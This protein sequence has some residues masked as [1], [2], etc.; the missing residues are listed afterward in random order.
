[1]AIQIQGANGI[2]AEVD[3]TTF[4]A[5]R[6]T[7]RPAEYGAFGHYRICMVSGTMAAALAANSDIFLFRWGDTTRLAVVYEVVISAGANVAASA[8]AITSLELFFARTFTASGTGGTPA[9]LSGNNQKMRTSMGTTLATDI[10]C[11][12]TTALG[13]GTKTLDAQ[14]LSGVAVGIWTGALTTGL[15]GQFVPRTPL[16]DVDG[17]FKHP[18]VFAQDEGFAIRNGIIF[19]A[20]LTWNFAVSVAWLEYTSF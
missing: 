2:V 6:V 15:S 17:G 9:T 16:I 18:I 10:R 3:G 19:P 20:A 13:A 5:L 11:A 4:R 7:P 14:S 12:T 1:M 8:A